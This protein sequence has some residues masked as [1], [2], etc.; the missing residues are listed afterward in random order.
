MSKKILVIGSTGH[1]GITG[2][3]WTDAFAMNIVDFD[4]VLINTIS[5]T[6]QILKAT[7]YGQ[8]EALRK[9]L[10]RLLASQGDIVVLAGNRISAER[11]KSDSVNNYEWSPFVVG[12]QIESG[13]TIEWKHFEFSKYLG[14]LKRWSYHFFLPQGCLTSELMMIC[15]NI[16][17]HTWKRET[18]PHLVNRYS[19]DL[20]VSFQFDVQSGGDEILS[21]G[22]FTLL[23]VVPELDDRAAINLILEDIT[24]QSQVTLAPKWTENVTMPGVDKLDADIA[25]IFA[26]IEGLESQLEAVTD[27]KAEKEQYKAL[28]Y[29]TDVELENIFARALKACGG[30]ISPAKYSAEEFLL[31]HKGQ[32]ILVECKG[33]GKSISLS[34]IRQL[35]DYMLRYE[36][37]E[38]APPKG[39]LFGNAWRNLPPD[40]RVT[41]EHPV[42]PNNVEVRAQQ[43]GMALLNSLDFF[44]ALGRVLVGEI[45][46][47]A[48]L[49]R[50]AASTGVVNLDDL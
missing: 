7:K 43:V 19:R 37:E 8:F 22:R 49:D 42:F 46:G 24:G 21:L 36:E 45:S 5:L 16:H 29:A 6:T 26:K 2:V 38:G 50:I 32:K 12:I 18:M 35:M 17:D 31:E 25:V 15:G 28:L 13:E 47:T 11:S 3:S 33:V 39:I 10:A 14:T 27:Q 41:S 23:P 9:N 48:V 34:H 30:K 44:N 20:A 4:V 1:T 40:Q